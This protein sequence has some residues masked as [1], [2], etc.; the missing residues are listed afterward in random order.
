MRKRDFLF[1]GIVI[2]LLSLLFVF[3]GKIKEGKRLINDNEIKYSEINGKQQASIEILEFNKERD[4]KNLKSKDS[5]INRLQEVQENYRGKLNNL[6]GVIISLKESGSSVTVIERDTVI[7]GDS[8]AVYPIYITE[9]SERWSNGK[10]RA[11]KDSIWRTFEVIDDIDIVQGYKSSGFFKKKVLTVDVISNNPNSKVKDLKSVQFKVKQNRFGL[12]VN[13]GVGVDVI[14]FKPCIY[15][16]V[17]GHFRI[18]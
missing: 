14:T 5:I 11:S 6:T 12:G 13:T 9:W 17:G 4:F 2:V 8:I 10:I 1:T 7:I 16:G 3:N 15:L 18:F